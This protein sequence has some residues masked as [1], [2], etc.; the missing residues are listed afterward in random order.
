[1]KRIIGFFLSLG[2]LPLLWLGGE[3]AIA[4]NINPDQHFA[5]AENIGWINFKPAQG[6]GVT[7]TDTSL[8]G[9][10]WSENAGWINLDPAS[11]GVIS[12]LS[13]WP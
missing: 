4:D 10:A 3:K 6:E 8:T 7:V 2:L 12:S 1:M 9:F 13:S 5:W 11:S